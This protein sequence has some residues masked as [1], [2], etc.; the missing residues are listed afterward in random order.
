MAKM[1]NRALD[2]ADI[3]TYNR[4]RIMYVHECSPALAGSAFIA[5]HMTA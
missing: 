1:A 3:S 5:S 2:T 4:V